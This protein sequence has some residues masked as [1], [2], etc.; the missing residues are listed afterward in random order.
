LGGVGFLR[1]LG[2]KSR[3]FCPAPNA[4]TNPNTSH[5][6]LHMVRLTHALIRLESRHPSVESGR[7]PPVSST[8]SDYAIQAY[9]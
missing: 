2:V 4:E 1:S 3:I 5:S 7:T 9:L 6:D 8:G